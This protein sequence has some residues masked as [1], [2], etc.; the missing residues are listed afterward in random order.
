MKPVMSMNK[1]MKR[2]AVMACILA[3]LV[4]TAT[5][6]L[7]GS[8]SM[9]TISLNKDYTSALEDSSQKQ[10]YGFSLEK[11]G[12]VSITFSHDY[13]ESGERLWAVRIL[14]GD[15]TEI[16]YHSF[17]GNVE[18]NVTTCDIGLPSG[19]Y[20]L[21]IEAAGMYYSLKNFSFRVNYAPSDCWET[22]LNDRM[23]RATPVLPDITYSGTLRN[24]K[25][26]DYYVF[27]LLSAG[28]VTLDFSH[29][30]VDSGENTWLVLLLDENEKK[31]FS[32]AY[33]GDDVSVRVS[34]PI[35]LSAGTYYVLVMPNGIAP[36]YSVNYSLAVHN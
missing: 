24:N 32:N 14:D 34:D 15:D 7:A 33:K 18:R 26:K 16:H 1:I 10:N 31:L 8:R 29:E 27:T 9:G 11:P 28:S 20:T 5:V 23:F 30:G 4:G 19:R 22:E 3:L 17:K 12:V 36:V 2:I 13:V 35:P 21:R 6:V 25:D